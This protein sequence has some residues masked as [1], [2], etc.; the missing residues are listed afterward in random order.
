MR[1]SRNGQQR[2]KKHHDGDDPAV[3]MPASLAAINCL[4]LSSLTA[5]ITERFS[6]NS[7]SRKYL[8]GE[9]MVYAETAAWLTA[10]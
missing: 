10:G 1:K 9:C 2:Q 3:H 6:K 5:G 4:K 7:A 8:S